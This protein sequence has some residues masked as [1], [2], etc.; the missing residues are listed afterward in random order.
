M[1]PSP[2]GRIWSAIRTELTPLTR[3]V[4]SHEWAQ[5]PRLPAKF[6]RMEYDVPPPL[7]D[8]LEYVGRPTLILDDPSFGFESP[9]PIP[10]NFLE[11][12]PREFLDLKPPAA[13]Q[14]HALPV[15]NRPLLVSSRVPADAKAP[16][17][18]VSD[19]DQA[20]VMKPG[21]DVPNGPQKH[22]DSSLA[23]PLFPPEGAVTPAREASPT[24]GNAGKLNTQ[25]SQSGNQALAKAGGD[26]SDQNEGATSALKL[27]PRLGPSMP[28]WL[29][30]VVAARNSKVSLR[31]P[32]VGSDMPLS[33]PSMFASASAGL[34]FQTWRYGL[35]GPT[36]RAIH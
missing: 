18:P 7:P 28:A 31:S 20:W 11:P 29:T 26:R 9:P 36:D 15:L 16:S 17:N 8:E 23:S 12:P 33:G 2:T 6:A 14:G 35:P 4:F 19:R 21:I 1:N 3:A 5:R 22:A 10:A 24:D 34:T 32:M 13:S 25:R 30:D 27:A